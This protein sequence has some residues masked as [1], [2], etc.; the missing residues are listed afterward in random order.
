MDPANAR[1][2]AHFGLALANL[3]VAKTTDPDDARR[4][5]AEADYLTR[6]AVKLASDN[7]EV[8]KLRTKVVTRLN[9]SSQ[10]KHVSFQII[11]RCFF[12]DIWR[13]GA[14]RPGHLAKLATKTLPALSPALHLGEGAEPDFILEVK[15]KMSRRRLPPLPPTPGPRDEE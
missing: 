6:R 10:Q 8:K 7:D 5:R 4:A 12:H 3:A 9:L 13:I 11:W 14:A 1:L 15:S 2:N